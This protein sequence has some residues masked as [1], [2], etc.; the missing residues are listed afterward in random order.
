MKNICK[1]VLL[2]LALFMLSACMPF[3]PVDI[4]LGVWRS[5]YPK[6]ILYLKEAYELAFLHRQDPFPGMYVRDGEE[7]RIYTRFITR[8]I[9]QLSI[10]AIDSRTRGGN[11]FYSGVLHVVG[12]RMYYT[13]G[14]RTQERTGL[15]QIIFHRV[16]DYPPINPEDWFPAPTPTPGTAGE[17]AP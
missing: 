2:T 6:I 15:T 16:F 12:D 10:H 11:S 1:V 9:L 17:V 7:I 4:P 14:S 5:E 3:E 13:L 8:E